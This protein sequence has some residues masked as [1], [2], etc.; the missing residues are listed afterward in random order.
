LSGG[1]WLLWNDE[2]QVSIRFSSQHVILTVVVHIAS[3]VDFALICVYG[4]PHH[5][6]MRVLRDQI[7][8]FM[9]DNQGKSVVCLGDVNDIKCDIDTTSIN[10]NKYRMRSF[11]SYV[12]KCGLFDLGY[13]GPAYTW[14]NKFSLLLLFLK[15]LIVAWL[16]LIGVPSTLTQTFS[17]FPSCL[18]IMLPY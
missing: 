5:R 15:G 9:Q 1:L 12:K 18:V 4:N 8:N 11:C 13:N 16:I 2:V 7:S 14:T 6:Q 3:N 17:I 10:V